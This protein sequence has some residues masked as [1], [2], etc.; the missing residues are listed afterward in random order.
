M[1][2]TAAEK[3]GKFGGRKLTPFKADHIRPT[4]DRVKEVIFNKLMGEM[5]GAQVLDL[6]S[7]TGSLALEAVSRGAAHVTAVEKNPKSIEIIKKNCELL[8]IAAQEITVIKK[9]VFSF[10]KGSFPQGFD[11]ILIDPPFTESLDDDVLQALALSEIA[12]FPAK[13]FIEAGK[14]ETLAPSYGTIQLIEKKDYGDKHLG[15]Y[16]MSPSEAA[17]E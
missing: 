14:R 11:V 16:R 7:G 6:F 12:R 8:K 9:D 13:I 2:F 3:S 15:I 10:L 17:K 5:E 1:S 4:T